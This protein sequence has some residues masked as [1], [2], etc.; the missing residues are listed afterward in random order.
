MTTTF[1][2]TLLPIL[3]LPFPLITMPQTILPVGHLIGTES[4]FFRSLAT[5]EKYYIPKYFIFVLKLL[6]TFSAIGIL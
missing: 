1:V 3:T 5:S 6:R 4:V 2:P